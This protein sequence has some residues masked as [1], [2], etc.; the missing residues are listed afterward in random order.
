MQGT[1][2]D[3][4]SPNRLIILC[5]LDYYLPGFKSGGPLRS[6]LNLVDQLGDELDFFIITRDRDAND[7]ESYPAI[8][9]NEWNV[10]GRSQVFYATPDQID[11]YSIAR[12]IRNTPHDV[13][14]LNSFFSL[15]FSIQPLIARKLG[16]LPIKPCILA[17]RGEFSK[18]ALE[19]KRTKKAIF[20]SAA[21]SIG[22]HNSITWQAS[23]AMERDQIRL[24]IGSIAKQIV[25]APDL[26]SDSSLPLYGALKPSERHHQGMLRL[27][28]I[29]RISAKK[30]LDF[31]LKI[32]FNVSSPTSLDIFGPIE[33]PFYLHKC[34][35]LIGL[36]PEHIKVSFMSAVNHSD[37]AATFGRYD[38]FAFPT[39]GENFGHVIIESLAAGTPVLVSDQTPWRGNEELALQE[40]SLLNPDAWAAA[41]D[42]WANLDASSM[43]QRRA[44]AMAYANRVLHDK[45]TTNKNL[46]LFLDS[47]NSERMARAA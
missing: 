29:S 41:I 44:A 13:L 30:N 1:L 6:I 47:I 39:R 14:Y 25:I 17:P 38:L 18:G 4:N 31:L 15:S 45:N 2:V 33:D 3:M 21:S 12:L 28:F 26:P 8:C 37:V 24:N 32:L 34:N 20:M 5:L 7:A 27:V 19:L 42:Q 35:K 40:I 22:L 36:L 16:L 11:L 9:V 43:F 10:V 23:S 46:N